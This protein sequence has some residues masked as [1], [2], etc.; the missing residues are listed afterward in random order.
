MAG[1]DTTTRLA[2]NP[3]TDKN[4][5]VDGNITFKK[6]KQN[7]TPEQKDKISKFVDKTAKSDIMKSGSDTVAKEE[8]RYGRNKSTVINKAYIESGD[9]RRKF[10]KITNDPEINRTLYNK[11]KE[12]LKHRSGTLYEDMYWIDA[13]SGKIVASAL[14]EKS[15]KAVAYSKAVKQAI[16]GNKNLIAIHTHPHSMPPSVVDFNSAYLNGYRIGVVACHDGKVFRY[17]AKEKINERL[18]SMYVE[19]F[20]IQGDNEYHSQI[21]ALRKIAENGIID[22][23]EV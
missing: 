11:A 4:Y 17:T 15:E 2:K 19:Q 8:Q 14:N 1:V 6:W 13:D 16:S 9:Y 18:Y 20:Q 21:K 22:F 5:K 3:E 10:D 12:M 23:K 7:L